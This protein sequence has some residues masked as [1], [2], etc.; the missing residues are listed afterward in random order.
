MTVLAYKV[1]VEAHKERSR[2]ECTLAQR[3]PQEMRPGIQQRAAGGRRRC[4]GGLLK[5]GPNRRVRVR[6]PQWPLPRPSVG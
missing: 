2:R 5:L 6:T 1:S 3:E 4:E